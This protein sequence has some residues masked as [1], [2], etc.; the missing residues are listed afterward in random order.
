MKFESE[1]FDEEEIK[2]VCCKHGSFTCGV[3]QT[4]KLEGRCNSCKKDMNDEDDWNFIDNVTLESHQMNMVNKLEAK[5]L[6]DIEKQ[7][8]NKAMTGY[9]QSEKVKEIINKRFGSFKEVK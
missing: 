3:L 2:K 8:V 5:I 1:G 9:E 7:I 6:E 4:L